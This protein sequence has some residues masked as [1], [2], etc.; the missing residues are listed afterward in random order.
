MARLVVNPGDR[1]GRLVILEEVPTIVSYRVKRMRMVRCRCDCGDEK[2]YKLNSLTRTKG[3]KSCNCLRN[4]LT[5]ERSTIHG[6]LAGVH[7]GSRIPPEYSSWNNMLCR[8]R[9]GGKDSKN[10]ADRGITVCDRWAESYAN[11]LKDMG[12]KPSPQHSIDRIDNNGNYEPS[13]CR[14]ATSKEQQRNTRRTQYVSIG[15][16]SKPVSEWCEQLEMPYTLVRHRLYVGWEP[17]T[18]LTTPKKLN[19]HMLASES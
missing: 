7:S 17:A 3:S 19:R 14:W 5:V 15:G 8:C 12:P 18:A 11:F 9:T 2:D 1:Y 16:V 10:Y 13:N 4:D 6:G